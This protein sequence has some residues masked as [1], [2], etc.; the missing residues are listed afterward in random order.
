MRYLSLESLCDELGKHAMLPLLRQTYHFCLASYSTL[1]HFIVF[2]S[3]GMGR[4]RAGSDLDLML[5]F[6]H[7]V[8]NAEVRSAVLKNLPVAGRVY[9]D[10]FAYSE[11]KF[12]RLYGWNN[13]IAH[14]GMAGSLIYCKSDPNASLAKFRSLQEV[15]PLHVRR[16][17]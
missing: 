5:L 14:A 4:A 17:E 6:S 7:E 15:T 10:V 8:D 9:V 12:V 16:D 1:T 3:L 2:G 11:A 13:S